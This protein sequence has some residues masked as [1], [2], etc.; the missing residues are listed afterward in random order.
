[1]FLYIFKFLPCDLCWIGT[2]TIATPI[3]LPSFFLYFTFCIQLPVGDS[4]Q[5]CNEE[6]PEPN[7][8]KCDWGGRSGAQPWRRGPPAQ[9]QTPQHRVGPPGHRASGQAL[10]HLW[11]DRD[12]TL[13]SCVD[14]RVPER[15]R[16]MGDCLCGHV[17][18][19]CICDVF[20]DT[21]DQSDGDIREGT[22]YSRPRAEADGAMLNKCTH[23]VLPY[24]STSWD[25]VGDAAVTRGT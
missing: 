5:G 6:V 24:I 18:I 4:H 7:E 3:L 17:V 23:L 20:P 15:L 22:L 21:G 8:P 1:M 16:V 11:P 19:Y 25:A 12:I 14:S 10:T 13:L 9:P 2:A